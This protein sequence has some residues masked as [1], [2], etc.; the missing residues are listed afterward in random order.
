MVCLHEYIIVVAIARYLEQLVRDLLGL[1]KLPT[2]DVKQ[3]QADQWRSEVHRALELPRN[4]PR[5][6]ESDSDLQSR[7]TIDAHERRTKLR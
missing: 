1:H 3:P 7:P 2:A 6:V 5:P 4:F